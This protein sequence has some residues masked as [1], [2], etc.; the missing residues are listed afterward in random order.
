MRKERVECGLVRAG[1]TPEHNINVPVLCS[2]LLKQLQVASGWSTNDITLCKETDS[3]NS[4]GFLYWSN[5]R[6]SNSHR[7]RRSTQSS[8]RV[9]H[10]G[11]LVNLAIL[12][13]ERRSSEGFI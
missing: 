4:R 13:Q 9:Y 5:E 12:S 6:I 7:Y 11:P 10:K 3:D 2:N 1:V 8:G